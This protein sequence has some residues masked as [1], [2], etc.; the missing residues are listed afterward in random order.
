M[1][2]CSFEVLVKVSAER[3]PIT[4]GLVS[5]G[6]FPVWLL[7]VEEKRIF[8]V[9]GRQGKVIGSSLANLVFLI[10]IGEDSVTW[11]WNP[12]WYLVLCPFLE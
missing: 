4:V 6:G 9:L 1:S 3:F 10:R 8:R 12:E 7:L 2:G 5:F 11:Y